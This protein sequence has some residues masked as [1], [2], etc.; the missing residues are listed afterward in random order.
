MH[1]SSSISSEFDDGVFI[2]AIVPAQF[3]TIADADFSKDLD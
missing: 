2:K 1:G 3:T